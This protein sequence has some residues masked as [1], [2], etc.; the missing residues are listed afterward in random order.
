MIMTIKDIDDLIN[1]CRYFRMDKAYIPTIPE[2]GRAYVDGYEDC[3]DDIV[4]TLLQIREE[5]EDVDQTN[6]PV[7]DS[8]I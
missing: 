7:E 2:E 5:L 4:G 3:R 8:T 1:I 6:V